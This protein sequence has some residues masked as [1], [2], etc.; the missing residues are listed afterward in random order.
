MRRSCSKV[1]TLWLKQVIHPGSAET[2]A[3]RRREKIESPE[4][5][6]GVLF[7]VRSRAVV[8]E[9]KKMKFEFLFPGLRN[10][11]AMESPM[12]RAATG[13]LLLLVVFAYSPTLMFDYVTQDQWRA[14]RHSVQEG[15]PLFRAKSCINMNAGFYARTGRPL[16]WIGECIEHAAVAKIPDFAHLRPY[17]LA[18]V[19]VTVAYL[20]L[21]VSQFMGGLAL[22]V[23]A[24]TAFVFSPGYSF[25]YL[26]GMTAVMVLV[27]IPLVLKS[28]MLLQEALDR[29]R[30][31]L[32]GAKLLV[33]P[34]GFFIAANLIYP[35]WAF[36]VITLALASFGFDRS[37]PF[38]IKA[39]RLAKT[40][41][42]YGLAAIIYY[43]A[44]KLS[45]ALLSRLTGRVL[46]LGAYEVS[47]Q[48][49]PGI[50]WNRLLEAAHYFYAMPPLNFSVPQGTAV[51]ILVIFSVYAGFGAASGEDRRIGRALMRSVVVFLVSVVLLAGSISPWLFS[52]MDALST[53]HL[54]PWYLFFCLAG[55]G[56][57]WAVVSSLGR[58]MARLSP[59]IILVVL[60][61]PVAAVQNKL[62][63]LEAAVSEVEIA[64]M[65]RALG[66]WLDHEGYANN[67]FLL[68]V[69]PQRERPLIVEEQYSDG[70]LNGAG[71]NVVLSSA[72]NPV[73]IPWMFNAL[74]RERT[75][76]PVGRTA[77]LINCEFNQVC[78][79]NIFRPN[80]VALLVSDADATIKSSASPYVVNLS[81]LTSR[82]G[83][84][85]I[86]QADQVRVVASS[87]LDDYGPYGLLDQM[88]PG[89]HAASPVTY[90]QTLT[91][92]FQAARK[93]RAV[94]LLPQDGGLG[95]APKNV[96]IESS[97][98]GSA[99]TSVAEVSDACS[100]SGPDSWRVIS[101]NKTFTARYLKIV[102]MSNCGDPGLLTLQGLKFE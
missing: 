25:M 39:V 13:L 5:G 95:R 98:A 75:D 37:R 42:F 29:F 4:A 19:V 68:V 90:P 83:Y 102:I 87:Q 100:L 44:V 60:A 99:W 53:R 45:I 24:G 91:I 31:G 96:R 65:R 18:V 14:F 55:F 97:M 82:P 33:A 94:G 78:A 77:S 74:L 40:M 88:Q 1:P 76:H 28:F 26:Q 63:F 62:S 23:A 34:A 57:V 51:A 92:D 22:G 36:L 72:K 15:T 85:K 54:I 70:V 43:L 52:H 16:V 20:G 71:E 38:G 50:L 41:I 89:W 49:S 30:P 32:D 64:A 9:I 46:H 80:E 86:V 3:H 7:A 35:V 58:K 17:V 59:L 81:L 84:P 21:A 93:I 6:R 56:L 79:S 67:R 12:S 101:F 66:K 69:R 2:D 11:W 27:T 73:S 61:T 47:M 10:R 48:L 8:L